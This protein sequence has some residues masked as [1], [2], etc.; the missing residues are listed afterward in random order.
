MT[1]NFKQRTTYLGT[2]WK[3]SARL[4]K[5]SE[6]VVG[7]TDSGEGGFDFILIAS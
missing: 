6:I 7:L 5:L 4:E 2:N 3:S 1:G